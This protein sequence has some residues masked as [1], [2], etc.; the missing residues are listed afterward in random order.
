[1]ILP[2][3]DPSRAK[4]GSLM[5]YAD[6]A[7]FRGLTV[8]LRG[9]VRVEA[10]APSDY[11]L[12]ALAV[13][14]PKGQKILDMMQG[15]PI[16]ASRWSRFSIT[17]TIDPDV[18]R[19]EFGVI[20]F[21]VGRVWLDDVSL[22]AEGPLPP[23][24]SAAIRREIE[25]RYADI[26]AAYADYAP[27]RLSAWTAAG[28]PSPLTDVAPFQTR[29]GDIRMLGAR[30]VHLK[31]KTSISSFE[32][33]SQDYATAAAEEEIE[34][35]SGRRQYRY[36]LQYHDIWVRGT[37][38]FQRLDRAADS[39]EDVTPMIPPVM[40]T[41]AAG[42]ARPSGFP[43]GLGVPPMPF[44]SLNLGV[45]DNSVLVRSR[46]T[47]RAAMI[48]VEFPDSPHTETTESLYDAL[49]PYS[50][51]WL[52]E[53]SNGRVKLEVTP[54]HHWYRMPGP[55]K[56]FLWSDGKHRAYIQA[57]LQATDGSDLALAGY[58][59]VYIISAE[60]QATPISPTLI[61]SQGFPVEGGRVHDV[62]TFGNDI[63]GRT[64]NAGPPALLHETGHLFGLP[65]LYR[66]TRDRP[67]DAPVFAGFW[68][69][70]SYKTG[71]FTAWDMTKLGWLEPEQLE[72]VGP[73]TETRTLAPIETPGGLKALAIPVSPTRAYVIE[74][75]EWRGVDTPVICEEGV[76]LYTVDTSV[77]TQQGPLRVI[78]GTAQPPGPMRSALRRHPEPAAGEPIPL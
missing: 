19:M 29:A 22:E 4:A 5:Q 23:D 64:P 31:S 12:L 61:D 63:H 78:G 39:V 75:R 73:G 59:M 28:P 46:G 6:P 72:C 77:P 26:D 15:R 51:R 74:S 60:N 47:V 44:P 24:A 42:Q 1:M 17:A 69:P 32:T 67:Q 8:V 25:Q 65:D 33:R 9:W 3:T 7:A 18:R 11:A 16:R 10:S 41:A 45:T 58:D 68:D 13:D 38:G 34:R 53:V 40:Q 30:G 37:D 50:Q 70:M 71:H 21:G 2:P 54:I 49:V 48:F 55:S 76:L 56:D 27:E 62:V 35:S 52:D 20:S 66:N 14:G 57:A 36:R 43:C